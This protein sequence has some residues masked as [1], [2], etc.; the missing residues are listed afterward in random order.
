MNKFRALLF[1][2]TNTIIWLILGIFVY[3][4]AL[5]EVFVFRTS[6]EAESLAL[7]S[8]AIYPLIP[9]ISY[10]YEKDEELIE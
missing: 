6:L 10:Y 1:S 7:F 5:L 4:C 9:I 8:M 2:Y 3:I